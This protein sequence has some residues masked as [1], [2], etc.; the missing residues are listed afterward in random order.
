MTQPT[1]IRLTLCK[2]ALAQLFPH[3]GTQP[4]A[5]HVVSFTNGYAASLRQLL[6]AHYG[7]PHVEVH[8]RP[9]QIG[10]MQLVLDGRGV[11]GDAERERIWDIARK[12]SQYA[13]A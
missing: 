5:L 7:I 3:L 8:V 10:R 9:E 13:Y 11:D 4:H 12:A 6:T 1:R 2:G